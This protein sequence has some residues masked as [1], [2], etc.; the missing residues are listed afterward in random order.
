MPTVLRWG[1]YRAF[2]YSNEGNEP[3]HIH[4]RSGDKEA[5]FWLHDLTVVTNAGYPQHEVGDI[6]RHLKVNRDLLL[7]AWNEHFGA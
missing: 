5:K 4:V 1:P 3:A 2:F 6:I 7:K